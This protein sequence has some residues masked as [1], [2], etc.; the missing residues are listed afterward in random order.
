MPP[1]LVIIIKD[2]VIIYIQHLI[3][4]IGLVDFLEKIAKRLET[5]KVEHLTTNANYKQMETYI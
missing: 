4:G 5:Y 1:E 3:I 2:K